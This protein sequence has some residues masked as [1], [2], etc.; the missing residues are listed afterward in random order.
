MKGPAIFRSLVICFARRLLSLA[1]GVS[2][3]LFLRQSVVEY[4]YVTK[5]CCDD[6]NVAYSHLLDFN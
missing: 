2:L 1:V 6:F 5:V 4:T 3:V